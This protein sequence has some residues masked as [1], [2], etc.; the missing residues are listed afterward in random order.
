MAVDIVKSRAD[1]IAQRRRSTFLGHD[2]SVIVMVRAINAQK[3]LATQFQELVGPDFGLTS[4]GFGV[5]RGIHQNDEMLCDALLDWPGE[6]HSWRPSEGWWEMP[7]IHNSSAIR[8]K[9]WL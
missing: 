6:P 5:E 1:A 7:K 2:T 9:A 8:T 3:E 4:H